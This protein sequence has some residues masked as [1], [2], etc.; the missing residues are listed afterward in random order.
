MESPSQRLFKADLAAA[1]F[2]SGAAKGLWGQVEPSDADT[3]PMAYFWLASAK[4]DNAPDRYVVRLDMTGYRSAAP[5][6][7]FWDPETKQDLVFAK[8]PQGK[9][10]SRFARVFRTDQWAVDNKG[11][12]H[13][14]DRVA[15]NGHPDWPNAMPQ[16]VWTSNRTIV[17]YL[18]EFQTLLN[19]GDYIGV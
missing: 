8:Y 2:L 3:W 11:F 12:Y 19:S 17:D 9:Q 14:Y 7:R 1:E 10:G 16:L 18:E 13:P 6:G 15:A 5:T 4:R